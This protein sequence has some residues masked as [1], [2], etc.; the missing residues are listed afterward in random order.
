MSFFSKRGFEQLKVSDNINIMM[1]N[2]LEK[3]I[4]SKRKKYII[5]LSD[6]GGNV[7]I[8]QGHQYLEMYNIN[9]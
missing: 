4:L 1:T 6:K 3:T 7:V 8:M 5:K 9:L 2:K